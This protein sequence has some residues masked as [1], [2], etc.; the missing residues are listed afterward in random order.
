MCEKA[1]CEKVIL[2]SASV[3]EIDGKPVNL[4]DS[5]E[6]WVKLRNLHA[7][8]AFFYA[9]EEVGQIVNVSKTD[10]SKMDVQVSC[11]GSMVVDPWA[12]WV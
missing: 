9:R 8:E 4:N 10:T 6:L 2:R 5:D 1:R 12:R 7:V 3:E 11:I